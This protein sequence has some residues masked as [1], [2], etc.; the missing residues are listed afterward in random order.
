MEQ[1]GG[2]PQRRTS[3]CVGRGPQGCVGQPH[4][5][6][7][8]AHAYNCCL[9]FHTLPHSCL[10]PTHTLPSTPCLQAAGVTNMSR[11]FWRADVKREPLQR[12]YAITFPDNKQLKEYQHRME[13]VRGRWRGRGSG[14]G[15]S[16][17][18][19]RWRRGGKARAALLALSSGRQQPAL[20][21]FTKCSTSCCCKCAVPFQ[22]LTA[23][24]PCAPCAPCL[25]CAPPPRP[26]SVTTATW[27]CSRSCSSSTPCPPAP[28][29]SCLTAPAST[30]HS[31]PTSGA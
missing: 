28:A 15:E 1:A 30:T 27:V 31:C 25:L 3:Y 6:Q 17:G 11:A 5:L 13:E 2:A 10:L 9:P 14:M 8:H 7:C 20:H 21:P 4:Q 16:M 26:R 19:E 24:P 23:S 29:S 12:V 22:S 18:V